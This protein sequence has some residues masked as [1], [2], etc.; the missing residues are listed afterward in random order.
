[1]AERGQERTRGKAGGL[2]LIGMIAKRGAIGLEPFAIDDE[3]RIGQ[4]REDRA[5]RSELMRLLE[6]RATAIL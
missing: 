2:R 6:M 4:F 1:M 5:T 3:T